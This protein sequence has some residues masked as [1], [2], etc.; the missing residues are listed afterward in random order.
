MRKLSDINSEVAQLKGKEG[1]R[2]QNGN[3]KYLIKKF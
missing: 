1:M 3:E 2:M